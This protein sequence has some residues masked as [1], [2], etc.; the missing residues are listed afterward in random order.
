MKKTIVIGHKNPDTDS[1]IS[2]IVG[3][4]YCKNILKLDAVA[5]RA[6]NI[7]N[8]TKFILERFKVKVPAMFKKTPSNTTM[9]LVD[10]NETS[11]LADGLK[12]SSVERVIDHHKVQIVT[13]TPIAIRTEPIGSTSALL[14]KLYSEAGKKVPATSAKLL[15][16]GILSDT[17]NLTGPT[18]TEADKKIVRELN[19]TAKLRLNE[20]AKEMFAAKSSLKGI[21]AEAVV[22]SDCKVFDMGRNRVGASVWETADP[23]SVAPQKGK[24]MEYLKKKK[25][26]EKLDHLFF[27]VVDILKQSSL[28]YILDEA[29]RNVAEKIFKIKTKGDEMILPGIASRKKQII[30][31]LTV[32]LTK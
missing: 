4:E 2:S 25:E 24:I 1:I 10:H 19:K 8:E 7:N 31:P 26:T 5:M 23:E 13:E 28:L 3:A 15:L 20:F 14:A 11:Q 22:E 12:F 16:A 18:T 32:E 30:P 29:E 17:L 6:G 21:S 9:T 27:F